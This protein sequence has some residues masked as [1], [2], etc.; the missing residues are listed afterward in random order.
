MIFGTTGGTCHGI[1]IKSNGISALL[2][3]SGLTLTF[4]LHV[5]SVCFAT[6]FYVIGCAASGTQAEALLFAQKTKV[7]NGNGVFVEVFL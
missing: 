5:R 3:L 2:L 1:A 4:P 7:G 6:S